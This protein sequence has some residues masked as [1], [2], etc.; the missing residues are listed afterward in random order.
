MCDKVEP[1]REFIEKRALRV[2]CV[3]VFNLCLVWDTNVVKISLFT[4]K[5][6]T[7]ILSTLHT[8][9]GGSHATC[10]GW[11]LRTSPN[12]TVA[13]AASGGIGAADI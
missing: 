7:L 9:R 6:F 3:S 12:F 5:L 2:L 1:R 13:H 11:L 8:G 4:V 10:V